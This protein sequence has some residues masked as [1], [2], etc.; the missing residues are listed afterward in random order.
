MP[1]VILRSVRLG[2]E[3]TSQGSAKLI[4]HHP[5]PLE[6]PRNLDSENLGRQLALETNKGAG[7][8]M[9]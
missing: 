2:L 1:H 5:L 7:V 8:G 4:L 3:N 9:S 6:S